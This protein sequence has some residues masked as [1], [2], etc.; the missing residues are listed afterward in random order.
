MKKIVIGLVLMFLMISTGIQCEAQEGNRSLLKKV[1]QDNQ[2]AVDAIAM[3][4]TETRRII[5]KATEYPEIISKLNAMQKNSQDSFEKLIASFSKDEQEKLWNLTRYE[6]L[7][8]DLTSNRSNSDAEF[9]AMLLNYPEEI[10]KTAFE[11]RRNNFELL[12]QIDR[13]NKGFNGEFE[14]LL[15]SYPPDVID[16]FREMIKMPAVLSLLFDHMQY[17]VVVGDYYKRNPERVLYKTDSL[18]YVLSQKNTQ[19]TEDWE[20][21]MKDDPQAQEEYTQ[22]AQ[23]YAKDNG[24]QPED[25]NAPLIEDVTNYN[26]NPFN[27]WFGYPTWYPNN[28]WNPYPYWYDW[29]FYYGPGRRV[30]FFGLPSAHFMDW[31]FYHPEFCSRYANLSNHYYNYYQRHRESMNYNSISRSVNEWRFRNRDIVTDAWDNDNTNRVQRFK[32]YGE[33]E[34]DRGVYNNKNPRQEVEQSEYLQKKHKKYPLLSSDVS[35]KQINQGES[36]SRIVQSNNS[37]F[38]R[39]PPVTIRSSYKAP[40]NEQSNTSQGNQNIQQQKN[41]NSSERR[42]NVTTQPKSSNSNGRTQNFNQI[43]NAQQYHQNTWTQ[44]QPKQQTYSAPKQQENRRVEQP[45]RQNN[46]APSNNRRK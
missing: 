46:Q 45:V 5:F 33:M 41:N 12:V 9:N 31:Y 1:M 27:W 32:E 7:I 14:T 29:G 21:S 38:V 6:G 20:K 28:Y 18:N 10:R 15:S 39:K 13:M 36:R 35:N 8:T 23:E 42:D 34:R 17:T 26:T 40:V 11:E 16:A 3:Y 2:E 19:E 44:I 25:Y 30:V 43:R 24:Y 37:E 4:P 22:A